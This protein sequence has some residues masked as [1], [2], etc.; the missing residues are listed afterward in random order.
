[1]SRHIRTSPR[2]LVFLA[3]LILA[4]AVLPALAQNVPATAREAASLPQFAARLAHPNTAPPHK[5]SPPAPR[6]ACRALPIA[7]G[8]HKTLPLD[9]VFYANGPTT[10]ICDIQGCTV[11]AWTVNFG[12]TVS[13]SILA[14]GG[15]SGAT[16]AFW[17]FPG[18][19]VTSLDWSLGTQ[20]FGSD[21][22]QG[23]ASGG[24]VTEQYI[25]S[26][27]Y[28]YEIA[29]VT[30]TGLSGNVSNGNWLTL[31]NAV[32]P[33]GDPVYWD[34]NNGPSAAQESAL[35][36]IPSESFNVS[37]GFEYPACF[38]SQP[39]DG[40]TIIHDFTGNED[41][42]TPS[43]V[44]IDKAG[45]LYG[46]A[47][48]GGSGNGTVFKVFEAGSSWI[49]NPL[50]TF[51]GAANGGA[52]G[53][54]IIGQNGILYGAAQGGLQNCNGG[55]CGLIFDLRPMPTACRTSSCAWAEHPLYQFAGP[56]DAA[57]GGALVAD[58]A[59]N[60]YG[61]SASG[62]AQQQGAVF[63]LTPSLG[64]WAET[65]LYSFTGGSDGAAPTDVIVGND[66]TLYGAAALGGANS[67]GVVFQ[68]SPSAGG[69]TET[70]LYD[71][72]AITF[73]WAT[74][75]PHSLVEDNAGN[76]FGEYQYWNYDYYAYDGI[77]FMLSSSNGKWVYAEL[78][79][80]D[81][82][83]DLFLNLIMDTAGNL[84]G[85]G[86]GVYGCAGSYGHGY[87][88]KLTRGSDGWQYSTPFVFQGNI[89]FPASGALALDA[90]GNLYGTTNDCGKYNQGTVWQFSP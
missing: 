50:Y 3:L 72:P 40:F 80:G 7:Q 54:V 85:A 20:P 32:V 19:T 47:Q 81:Q 48:S 17:L 38:R 4:L 41:G 8:S 63:Q 39:Q 45:S 64:G 29:A 69:W 88:F 46:A 51:A 12:Y 26:N 84:W 59:G 36:T 66:G 9:S 74:S 28:G 10:G 62:G 49:L 13:N 2:S 42:G 23:T 77:V 43:G 35:G 78:R 61:V 37:G 21:L 65:I 79:R 89:T 67:G 11:D 82:A 16:F 33:S 5:L 60:L 68:L 86:G 44:A 76:L 6:G 57:D 15:V 75:N 73:E 31:G 53:G 58:H 22:G 34:E 52:P 83:S 70:V 71:L 55:Y 1:V 87:I 27:Q 18:D 90:Q 24:N 56:T 25:S 14:A 30:V